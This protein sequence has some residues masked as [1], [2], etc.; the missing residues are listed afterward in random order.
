M[1]WEWRHQWHF[2]QRFDEHWIVEWQYVAQRRRKQHHNARGRHNYT[3]D[4]HRQLIAP[5]NCLPSA[6]PARPEERL[7]LRGA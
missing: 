1:W 7:V 5:A 3:C 4:D 6:P 2:E